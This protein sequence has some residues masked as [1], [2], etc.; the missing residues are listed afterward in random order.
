MT[1]CYLPPDTSK[2]VALTLRLTP[3]REASTRACL[4]QHLI[5][6]RLLGIHGDHLRSG[7]SLIAITRLSR[8][9]SQSSAVQTRTDRAFDNCD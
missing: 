2:R 5:A 6:I 7:A 8:L 3:A 9:R 1:L 4:D